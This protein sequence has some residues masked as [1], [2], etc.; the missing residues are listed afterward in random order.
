MS[1]HIHVLLLVMSTTPNHVVVS[2]LC[3]LCASLTVV[4]Y[5]CW[6]SLWFDNCTYE[7]ITLDNFKGGGTTTDRIVLEVMIFFGKLTKLG[8]APDPLW[9]GAS[10][11]K[12]WI[13]QWTGYIIYL[14]HLSSVSIGYISVGSALSSP[15]RRWKLHV[16]KKDGKSNLCFDT[17]PW[18][19]DLGGGH[20]DLPV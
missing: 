14:V 8:W 7:P 12:A 2:L 17:G 16:I 18:P 6:P 4:Q 9:V 15:N 3:C 20:V 19:C 11:G 10:S 5:G 13:R 1:F